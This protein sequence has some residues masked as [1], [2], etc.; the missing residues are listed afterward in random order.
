MSQ[1]QRISSRH[2]PAFKAA[3][4]L[5]QD[6]TAYRRTAR[7]WLEG[8]HLCQ[9]HVLSAADGGSVGWRAKPLQAW[10]SDSAAANPALAELAAAAQQV[11]QADDALFDA[12]SPLP[13]PAG[14]AYV[15]ELPE[16]VGLQADATT[17]V[18]ERVQDAGNV[19]SILRSAAAFGFTQVIALPGSAGLWSPKV[20]RAGMGAHFG[21]RL[22]ETADVGV[23]DALALPLLAT[24][25][26]APQSLHEANLPR[27]AAWA[28]GNE[29]QG[30][31]QPLRQRCS[32]ELRI[33]QPGGQE[34]LNV[35]AAAAICLYESAR[36]PA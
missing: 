7:V 34:S 23:L 5:A 22:I 27:R 1:W 25:S 36:S 17:V 16:A 12:L 32:M 10:L 4:A 33:P 6:S 26:H 18:L 30:L 15:L 3:K 21:L 9:A 8:E 13:A 19:G 31:S 2:N 14:I 11:W 24:S 29:G 20:L 28:F 35:A